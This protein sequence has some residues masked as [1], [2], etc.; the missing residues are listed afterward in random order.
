MMVMIVYV[1]GRYNSLFIYLR[2]EV[3]NIG[4][5]KN[6]IGRLLESEVGKLLKMLF[7]CSNHAC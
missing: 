5:Q 2:E 3:G 6:S 1:I 7:G 4:G